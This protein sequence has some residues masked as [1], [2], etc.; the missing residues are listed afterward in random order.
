MSQLFRRAVRLTAT[1]IDAEEE[2]VV[3]RLNVDFTI[4]R[5]VEKEPST[6]RATVYNL[7]ES[8]R[9]KFEA[10]DRIVLTLEAGY[11][12][13]LHVLFKGDLRHAR[14]NRDGADIATELEA[15]DGEK[16]AR[17]WAQRSFPKNTS[18]RTIF[19]HLIAV[20]EIGEG[21][22]EQGLDIE[23]TNGLPDEI[24]SGYSVRGYALD[25]L[26]ELARSRGIDFSVQDGEAQFLPIGDFRQGIPITKATP[27]TGLLG[28]PTIDNEGIMSCETMLLPN[29]FPGSRIDV[30]SEFVTGRF[31][32]LRAEYTGSVYGDDF[33]ISIEG[34]ELK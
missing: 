8:T 27:K 25:E 4:T 20:A 10:N 15:G 26:N 14:T 22:L 33:T 32:V 9:A 18:I 30:E 34:R 2:T 1:N 11:G 23:E 19:K 29:V 3:E 16:G 5:T 24:V 13:E 6:L 12:D 21:N 7:S 31:K 28:S 17:N